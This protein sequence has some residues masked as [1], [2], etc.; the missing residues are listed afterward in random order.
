L[1]PD[2]TN[3]NTKTNTKTNTNH[4][5]ESNTHAHKQHRGAP[6][7]KGHGLLYRRYHHRHRDAACQHGRLQ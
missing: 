1:P 7:H 4:Q 6:P 3:P 2:K 5:H